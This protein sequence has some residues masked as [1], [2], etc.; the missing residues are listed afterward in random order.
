[1]GCLTITHIPSLDHGT[2]TF[3]TRQKHGFKMVEAMHD[4][5]NTT[6]M[7]YLSLIL[8]MMDNS[9]VVAECHAANCTVSGMIGMRW[10]IYR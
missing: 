4:I 1:M 2:N 6:S 8:K 5:Y 10:D 9:V 3:T 7:C